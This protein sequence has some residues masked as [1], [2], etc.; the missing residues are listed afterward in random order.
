M[1]RADRIATAG[2]RTAKE[3]REAANKR[4]RSE[5]KRIAKKSLTDVM[6]D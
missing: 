4:R 1:S 6:S 2:M 5:K 3:A